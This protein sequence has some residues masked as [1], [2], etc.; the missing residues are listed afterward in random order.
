M[1][2]IDIQLT[3]N[4]GM[5]L[6]QSFQHSRMELSTGGMGVTAPTN[7]KTVP[8]A[9]TQFH[10]LIHFTPYVP[11]HE[12]LNVRWRLRPEVSLSV[13]AKRSLYLSSILVVK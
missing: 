7:G 8:D 11:A 12:G 3:G 5:D 1:I 6:G 9:L 4:S 10:H 13:G 2:A